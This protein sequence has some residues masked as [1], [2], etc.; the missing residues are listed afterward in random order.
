MTRL[1]LTGGEDNFLDHV[2]TTEV[3][4]TILTIVIFIFI[5][6]VLEPTGEW[7]A[8][9]SLPSPRK[10]HCQ[11]HHYSQSSKNIAIWMTAM[12]MFMM[13]TFSKKESGRMMMIGEK[14]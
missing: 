5:L 12:M 11:V 2:A 9:V 8:G 3:Y 10:Q 14:C 4:L 13:I 7:V 1:V 6:K